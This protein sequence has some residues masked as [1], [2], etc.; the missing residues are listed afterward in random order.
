M[1][2][3]PLSSQKALVTGASS[4]LGRAL[5]IAL[6][7]DNGFPEM[8]LVAVSHAQ[9]TLIPKANVVVIVR[10]GLPPDLLRPTLYARGGY[11]AFLGRISPETRVDHAIA[12]AR[13]VGLP[14]KIAAKVDPVD[15]PYY[16]S[17]IQP[18]LSAPNVEFM[19][20]INDGR[21]SVLLGNAHA[22][23]FPI[24]WPKSFGL[25]LIESLAC[26]T[27][28]LASRHGTVPDIVDDGITSRIVE[29]VAEAICKV[30]S[31]L[32]LNRCAGRRR[33]EARFTASRMAEDYLRIY[34]RLINGA[35][36]ANGETPARSTATGWRRA[37]HPFK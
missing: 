13:A 11:L 9:R 18:L 25:V 2:H 5:A 28:V 36:F 6:A 1:L 20:E 34:Q 37:G 24:D 32:A 4:G 35:C 7:R 12:T 15:E 16:R 26:G 29:S 30:G 27:P 19:G 21:K 3:P 33:F 8:P 17:E 22:L 23:V 10:H 31:V 14:I